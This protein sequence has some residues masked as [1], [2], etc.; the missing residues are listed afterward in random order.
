MGGS[1]SPEI[2]K[3]YKFET[4]LPSFKNSW[5]IEDITKFKVERA[6]SLNR[7]ASKRYRAKRKKLL[8]ILNLEADNEL[9]RNKFLKISIR[10]IE[11]EI[12]RTVLDLLEECPGIDFRAEFFNKYN[13]DKNFKS[14]EAARKVYENY[15]VKV[16][17]K[18]HKADILQRAIMEITESNRDKDVGLFSDL[19][20]L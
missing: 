2:R 7:E 18:P 10:I 17:E 1:P 4:R 19:G 8:K 12:D 6:K 5:K 16:H 3:S 9:H 13:E 11:A 15:M 14:T 20:V